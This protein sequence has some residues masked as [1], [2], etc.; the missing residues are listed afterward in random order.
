MEA[1]ELELNLPSSFPS[2][3]PT[4]VSRGKKGDVRLRW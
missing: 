1:R 3:L 4:S 2:R